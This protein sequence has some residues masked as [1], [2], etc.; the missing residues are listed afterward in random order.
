MPIKTVT[1]MTGLKLNTRPDAN[2]RFKMASKSCKRKIRLAKTTDKLTDLQQPTAP[3][4][5]MAKK[6]KHPDAS[7]FTTIWVIVI[8]S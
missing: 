6:E 7:H 4:K 2:T 8:M 3:P 5:P 1:K